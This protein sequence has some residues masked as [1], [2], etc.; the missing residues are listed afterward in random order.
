M[1]FFIFLFLID[2]LK[3]ALVLGLRA[4]SCQ[5][6]VLEDRAMSCPGPKVALKRNENQM[7]FISLQF[8]IFFVPLHAN[9]LWGGI[10]CTPFKP[11]AKG[12]HRRFHFPY[13]GFP[14]TFW[15]LLA[16]PGASGASWR[17]LTPP[18]ASWHLLAPPGASWL[19]VAPP[20][21]SWRLLSPPGASWCFPAL[22][23]ASWRSWRLL[24]PPGSRAPWR[25]L[26]HKLLNSK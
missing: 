21:A 20:G 3:Y 6:L 18:G 9:L 13:F 15:C 2:F 23:G 26:A 10:C 16:P 4:R 8:P 5:I 25:L 7:F 24:A 22:P 19:L 17:L 11:V 12:M 14:R 1:V